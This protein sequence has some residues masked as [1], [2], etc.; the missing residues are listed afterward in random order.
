MKATPFLHDN[1][2]FL[3]DLYIP[4]WSNQ[5]TKRYL[6][7]INMLMNKPS[8]ALGKSFSIFVYIYLLFGNFKCIQVYLYSFGMDK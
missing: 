1:K 8:M 4:Y 7:K 2:S 6:C 5:I 3:Y